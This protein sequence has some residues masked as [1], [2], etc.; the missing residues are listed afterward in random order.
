MNDWERGRVLSHFPLFL[1]VAVCCLLFRIPETISFAI[2]FLVVIVK[3][4]CQLIHGMEG[5]GFSLLLV[6]YQVLEVIWQSLIEA[7]A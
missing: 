3:G 5:S 1:V 2:L 7:M 4:N 6:C